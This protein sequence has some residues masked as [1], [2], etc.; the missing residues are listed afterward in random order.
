MNQAALTRAGL[1]LRIIPPRTGSE[2]FP[3]PPDYDDV[4]AAIQRL[5]G[6]VYVADGALPPSF[7]EPDGR[8][9]S[10]LDEISYHLTLWNGKVEGCLRCT[11]Y[12]SDYP[13]EKYKV[14]E[15]I[16]RMPI[17]QAALYGHSLKKYLAEWECKGF[18][19]GETGGLA[20]NETFRMN[21]VSMA[22]PLAGWSLARIKKRQVWIASA[23]ERNRS[24]EILCRLGGWRL[25]HDGMEL[26]AFFDAAYG[27]K[28]EFIGFDS[29]TLNPKFEEAAKEMENLMRAQF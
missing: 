9:R 14:F 13:V 4:I 16:R 3:V 29:D 18:K 7:I 15:L 17:E 11:L 23:T 24:A 27:C 26:P 10:A 6:S 12:P 22:I 28:M 8:H 1:S 25:K 19:V 21:A 20:I 2:F 5:R